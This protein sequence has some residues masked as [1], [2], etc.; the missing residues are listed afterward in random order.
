MKYLFKTIISLVLILSLCVCMTGC[1]GGTQEEIPQEPIEPVNTTE[2]SASVT[3]PP[4]DYMPEDT[5][6]EE[7]EPAPLEPLDI[8]T[9]G[10]VVVVGTV[11]RDE[12]GWF[13]TPEQ[14]LNVEYHY[15]LD[16]P[17]CFDALQRIEL[18][19]SNIDGIEKLLY[20]GETVTI[21]GTFRFYRDYFDRLYMLPYTIYMG[22]T[23]QESYGAPELAAPDLTES[24][25]DPAVPLPERMVPMIRDGKYT[26]NAFMLSQESLELMGNDFATFYCDFVDAFLNYETECPCPSK[27]FAEMLSTIIYFELPVYNVCAETF[28]FVKHYDSTEETVTIV[29]KYDQ[30]GHQQKIDEFMA[31][32]NEFLST[33]TPDLSEAE[34]AKNIYHELCT[35]V[36]YDYSALEDFERKNAFYAY[37]DHSGVCVTFA[38]VYNQLLTQVGIRATT[39]QCEYTP[40]MGHVWS[41]ITIDGNQ[42]FCD[43]T[44]ELN[45]DEGSGYRYFGQTYSQRV[46]DGL[47]SGG[48]T[49]GRYYPYYVDKSLLSPTSLSI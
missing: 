40:T 9:T 16:N 11:C 25:Y 17:T 7:V 21:E 36:T 22:K 33:A 15:F 29:Y 20:L 43:P 39:A 5:E 34:L 31:A 44:F 28:E 24:C 48:I 19:D 1:T 37:M 26:Y 49:A 18:F 2:P 10:G 47:G 14:P 4:E 3:L 8:S 23:V 45:F 27:D 41:L 13:L 35:R 30:A 6:P 38:N 12:E 42:Y 46:E 32:A